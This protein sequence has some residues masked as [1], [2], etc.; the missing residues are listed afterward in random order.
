[1]REPVIVDVEAGIDRVIELFKTKRLF[2]FKSLVGLR[3]ELGTYSRE[4]DDMGQPTEKI[5]DKETFHR[6]DAL[7]YVVQQIQDGQ[8][9]MT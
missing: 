4:L 6:L 3:D 9:F 2:I 5:K 1:V 8:W 7:R